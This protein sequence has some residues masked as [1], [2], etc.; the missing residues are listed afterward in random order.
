M[1]QDPPIAPED[2]IQLQDST[3]EKNTGGYIVYVAAGEAAD[4][5]RV[6]EFDSGELLIGKGPACHL[7]LTDG[8]VSKKHLCLT[9]G[10]DGVCIEDLGS[11]NGTKYFGNKLDKITLAEGGRI[12]VGRTLIDIIPTANSRFIEPYLE[13]HYGNLVGQSPSTR[14]LFAYLKRLEKTD[15]PVLIHGET[16][17]GKELISQALHDRSE[18]HEKPFVIVDCG[19]LAKELANSELFG[20]IKGSFTG[21]VGDKIGAFGQ[22]E[23]GT[24]FLDEIGELPLEVQTHL[25]RVLEAGQIKRVGDASYRPVSVRIVAAT[26]RDLKELVKEGT[27]REDLYFRLSVFCIKVPPLRERSADLPLLIK[28]LQER[29]GLSELPMEVRSAF[30]KHG[31]PG[32]IRELRN[33]LQRFHVLGELP[34]VQ[35]AEVSQLQDPSAGATFDASGQF[36]DE[37]QRVIMQFEEHYLKEIWERTQNVSKASRETGL[38]RRQLRDLLRKYGLYE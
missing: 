3:A 22:A 31:W 18:R 34:D 20:H 13:D 23:G 14:K 28:T 35:P 8:S 1:T 2:T 15:A 10:N 11:T 9:L 36:H 24:I 29:M 27:F 16:G 5:G 26:H 17:T 33:A 7:V 38:S 21:A 12:E 6:L 37:K 19:T 32:N 25:L 30:M 4:K